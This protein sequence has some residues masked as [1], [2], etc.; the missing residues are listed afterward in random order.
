MHLRFF[1]LA[2]SL[3]HNLH[4][5]LTTSDFI[6]YGFIGIVVAALI[7]YPFSMNYARKAS[8]WVLRKV[9]QEA[10]ISM[11][12]GLIIVLSYSEGGLVGVGIS[13]TIALFGGI[14]NRYFGIHTG[15]QFMAYYAS[16]W[17]VKTIFGV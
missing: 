17:L 2:Q 11:F 16:G 14:L 10:I 3:I 4:T 15:V 13:V 8:S 12:S 6:L 5:L 7:A 9:S 1:P